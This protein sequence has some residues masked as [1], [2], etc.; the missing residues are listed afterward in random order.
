MNSR[1]TTQGKIANDFTELCG[2]S[3][4][5]TVM[6]HSIDTMTMEIGL[7]RLDGIGDRNGRGRSAR[8]APSF[9][10]SR[11]WAGLIGAAKDAAR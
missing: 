10:V 4:L 1:T 2:I 3:E 8:C 11:E 6:I 9:V 7:R 5:E